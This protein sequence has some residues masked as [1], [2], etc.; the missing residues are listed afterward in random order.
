MSSLH[1]LLGALRSS[2]GIVWRADRTNLVLIVA[3]QLVVAISVAVQLLALRSLLARLEAQAETLS[4]LAAPAIALIATLLLGAIANVLMRELRLVANE[5]VERE[6]TL[7]ALRATNVATLSEFE[8]AEFHDLLRRATRDIGTRVWGAVWASIGF[9]TGFLT[10]AAISITLFALAPTIFAIAC[11]SA[12]PGLAIARKNSRTLYSFNYNYTS[13]DRR[14]QALERTILD[15]RTAAELRSIGGGPTLLR[16]IEELFDDRLR[17]MRRIAKTRAIWS[18]VAAVLGAILAGIAIAALLSQIV[19]GSLS[20]ANGLV[21]LIALQQ[22][23]TRARSLAMIASDLD[24]AGLYLRDFTDFVAFN[25][26]RRQERPDMLGLAAIH[27]SGLSFTYPGATRPAVAD[28]HLTIEPGEVIALVGE[29][30]S[31]KSTVAKLLA[32][33]YEPA[34]GALTWDGNSVDLASLQRSTAFM[35]QDFAR[36][37]LSIH[38]NISLGSSQPSD[39]S[40]NRA[41]SLAGV[42]AI[43]EHLPHGVS[44]I[45]SREFEDGVNL[46]G[47]QWQ[48]VALARAVHQDAPLVILDEPSSALDPRAE[49]DL[50]DTIRALYKNRSVVYISHRF[51]AV[52]SADRIYVMHEGHVT[53]SGSHD[54]LMELGLRYHEMFSLQAERYA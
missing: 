46:S 52:R 48:R 50:F 44:T 47:G 36:F 38:D 25:P 10:M 32:G 20:L 45:L 8:D 51:N 43:A 18:L 40:V 29:N 53:E 41:A 1:R 15:Q 24:E 49:A 54:E 37:P 22:L 5:S 33:L 3:T 9:V 17:R 27:A 28:L 30:G 21:A 23:T 31:G 16:R 42:D 11:V 35:F 14:R 39:E 26:E 34:A 2:F 7:E 6:A 12:L 13:E 4:D 19:D